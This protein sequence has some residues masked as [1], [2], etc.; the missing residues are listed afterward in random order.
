MQ[1]PRSNEFSAVHDGTPRYL[2]RETLARYN[3]NARYSEAASSYLSYIWLSLESVFAN[4]HFA[5]FARAPAQHPLET[6]HDFST[7][8][9]E[10]MLMF[11]RTL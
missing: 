9:T 4:K 2:L 1:F 8:E 6:S 5:A 11:E 3:L 10:L 7:F